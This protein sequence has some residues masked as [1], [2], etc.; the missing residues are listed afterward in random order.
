[1]GFL[2]DAYDAAV[3]HAQSVRSSVEDALHDVSYRDVANLA[4]AGYLAN[5]IADSP[6]TQGAATSVADGTRELANN[7]AEGAEG[8]RDRINNVLENAGD[9]AGDA[10]DAIRWG[11]YALWAVTVLAVLAAIAAVFYLIA[12]GGPTFGAGLAKALAP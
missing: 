8:V 5:E 6:T 9:A 10:A 2:N 4:P 11:Y 7:V 1:V 12:R 3:D